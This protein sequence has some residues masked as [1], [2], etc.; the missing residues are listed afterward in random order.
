[1]ADHRVG[2]EPFLHNL[3]DQTQFDFSFLT[4]TLQPLRMAPALRDT[5][6]AALMPPVKHRVGVPISPYMVISLI[7]PGSP[8]CPSYRWW[9]YRDCTQTQKTLHSPF[10]SATCHASRASAYIYPDLH[11]LLNT[12]AASSTLR[13][14]ESWFV[15]AYV[16]YVME[17]IGLVFVSADREAF[18]SL[19]EWKAIVMEVL[20]VKWVTY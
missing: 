17:D 8:L 3:I 20:D 1:M 7:Y 18:E 10:R 15:H 9:A 12:L 16:S 14:S 11:L 5:A 2:T 4:A 13:T 19:R 6:A